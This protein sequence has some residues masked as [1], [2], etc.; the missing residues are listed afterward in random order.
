MTAMVAER[1][2]KVTTLLSIDELAQ[3]QRLADDEG[4]PATQWV[5]AQIKR[6]YAKRF[7]EMPARPA[8]AT[9]R[10]LVEDLTGRAHYTAANIAERMGVLPETVLARLERLAKL[11]IVE[12]VAT[13]GRDSTWGSLAGNR[14]ATLD[15]LQKKNLDLDEPLVDDE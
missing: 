9:T 2:N 14:E 7:G 3:L 6:A 13:H 5:R 8:P 4:I 12:R 15:A 11:R 1:K 10:G